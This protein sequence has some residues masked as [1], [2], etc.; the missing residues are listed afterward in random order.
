MIINI[1][2]IKQVHLQLHTT[3][4]CYISLEYYIF[5]HSIVLY[6]TQKCELKRSKE[7]ANKEVKS[8]ALSLDVSPN[9]MKLLYQ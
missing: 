7:V 8:P 1:Q 9:L 6:I 5:S 4:G 2:L 3:I